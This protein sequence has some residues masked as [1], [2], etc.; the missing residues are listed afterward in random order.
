MIDGPPPVKCFAKTSS[1]TGGDS[2][3]PLTLRVASR[4]K[5]P[6]YAVGPHPSS[7]QSPLGE[8]GVNM[9]VFGQQTPPFPLHR[10]L[11]NFQSHFF[12]KKLAAGIGHR[13]FGQRRSHWSF[14][15]E[16]FEDENVDTFGTF[17]PPPNF[18]KTHR[19]PDRPLLGPGG[20]FGLHQLNWS[21]L[22]LS[23]RAVQTALRVALWPLLL[24]FFGSPARAEPR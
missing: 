10:T 3:Q 2:A 23:T 20:Q 8:P 6:C 4:T 19:D 16:N 11:A 21:P 17:H 14:Y 7:T 5:G 1:H 18:V 24:T 15:L 22:L 12:G 9:D 13:F